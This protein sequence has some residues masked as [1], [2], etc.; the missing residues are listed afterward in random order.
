MV[1]ALRKALIEDPLV[2]VVSQQNQQHQPLT[3][4][5]TIKKSENNKIGTTLD[6]LKNEGILH[7]DTVY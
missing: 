6:D 3:T 5:S 1:I 7:I 2:S 4:T